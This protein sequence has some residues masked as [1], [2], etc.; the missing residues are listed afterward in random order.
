MIA[1]V[2]V[3]VEYLMHVIWRAIRMIEI[4]GLTVIYVVADGCSTNRRFFRLHK[5]PQYQKSGVTYE[6]P[7]I[8]MPGN[9]IYFMADAP[10]VLK[11]VRN[12]WY[13]SKRNGTRKLVV[14]KW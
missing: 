5:I 6:A 12:A 3:S 8:S 7:N 9:K 1:S 10:H 4:C 14:I 13:N 11:T 2:G